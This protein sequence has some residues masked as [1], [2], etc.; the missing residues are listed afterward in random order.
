MQPFE[1]TQCPA[2]AAGQPLV[3]PEEGTSDYLSHVGCC[4]VEDW[5]LTRVPCDG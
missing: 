3:G 5:R 1:L 4:R 2:K